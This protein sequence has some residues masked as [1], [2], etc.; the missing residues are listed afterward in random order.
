[1][2]VV[3][4]S[5]SAV[6]LEALS[7]VLTVGAGLEAFAMTEEG[8]LTSEADLRPANVG[9]MSVFLKVEKVLDS[10]LFFSVDVEVKDPNDMAGGLSAA[11]VLDSLPSAASLAGVVKENLGAGTIS[12]GLL[13]TLSLS[14]SLSLP[15]GE[16]ISVILAE[17]IELPK[18]AKGEGVVFE[19]VPKPA[20]GD[21]ADVVTGLPC[22]AAAVVAG[23][24]IVP[25]GMVDVVG[26]VLVDEPKL[27]A[28]VA[29]LFLSAASLGAAK[30][31]GEDAGVVADAS[32]GLE[33]AALG[34]AD[35]LPNENPAK[36]D[37]GAGAEVAGLLDPKPPNEG[38]ADV[39]G[40]CS[41]ESIL[42]SLSCMVFAAAS[43]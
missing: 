24:L 25:N 29:G 21:A 43:C 8:L 36:G 40:G 17:G 26:A 9:G 6:E 42:A 12:V 39:V 15:S 37:A 14:F 5:F 31:K 35:G 1:M 34:V 11:V 16:W 33:V 38:A 30:L 32:N 41:S 27:N 18:P 28:A 10:L 7:T 22:S 13:D 19:G 23:A 4:V 2:V 3:A 20:K